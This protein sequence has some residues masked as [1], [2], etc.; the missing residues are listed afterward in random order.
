MDR[1]VIKHLNGARANQEESFSL[2]K[3]IALTIGRDPSLDV[4]FDPNDDL[5]SRNHAKIERDGADGNKFRL[6]DTGSR[7]GVFINGAKITS[8]SD[9]HHGDVVR[10]GPG[11]PEFLFNLD[12]PPP[13]ALKATRVVETSAA[14]KTAREA[15]V[16]SV[17]PPPVRPGVGRE[18]VERMVSAAESSSKKQMV[19]WVAGLVGVVVLASGALFWYQKKQ[20]AESKQETEQVA[21][22]FA[23]DKK[24]RGEKYDA[25]RVAAEYGGSTV[26]IE[27]SWKLIDTRSKK[28]VHHK[29]QP[30]KTDVGAGKTERR[31]VPLYVQ[32]ADGTIEPWLTSE[33]NNSL[34]VG[35]F[36]SGSG[37]VVTDNGFILTNRHVA[38]A[39][40]SVGP[41]SQ[42]PL[43][44][45][46]VRVNDPERPVTFENN[47]Q[48]RAALGRWVPARSKQT[49]RAWDPKNL[50]GEN[51]YFDV[52][53]AKSKTRIPARIVKVSDEADVALIKIDTPKA[54]KPVQL[55]PADTYDTL[56]QGEPVIVLGYPGVSPKVFVRTESQDPFVN[57]ATVVSV[58][59]NTVSVGAI[60]RLIRGT[61]T[62][63][64]GSKSDYFSEIRDMYQL[65]INSTGPGNSGGPTF[66]EK[67]RVIG[68]YSA[69][70][71]TLSFAVP[72]KYGLDLMDIKQVIK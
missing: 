12:P 71:D 33:E 58:P 26:Y 40:S 34:I 62:P 23:D 53:F 17:E 64:G 57:T 61:Q 6:V 38:E 32:L 52:T 28:A 65:T 66:D 69:G 59:D 30:V 8:N 72:I 42:L 51:Q 5:V 41:A 31:F 54:L 16:T 47:A 22:T 49:G 2:D 68:I 63:T 39:W 37:Y 27:A 48:N 36:H 46:L 70:N 55:A 9:L 20:A 13:A 3:F 4:K 19:N 44:G 24:Q 43:P 1:I 67:G 18:T 60:G 15:T 14:M 45:I 11:G 35:G 10:L 29:Y 50:I 56:K 21:K 25:A 7:N